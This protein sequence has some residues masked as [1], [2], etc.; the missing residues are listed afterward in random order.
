MWRALLCGEDGTVEPLEDL[1]QVHPAVKSGKGY[2]WLDMHEPD[3]DEI[4]LLREA[5][6]LDPLA[7][8]DCVSEVHHPKIDDYESYIYLAVH[9]VRGDAPRGKIRTR[10]LDVVLSEK[11]LITHRIDPSRSIDSTWKKCREEDGFMVRGTATVLQAVLSM[12]ARHFVDEV[13]ELQKELVDLEEQLFN[14]RKQSYGERVFDIKADIARLRGILVSQRDTLRRI[15]KGEFQVV[16]KR[17]LKYFSDVYD[18]IHRATEI[19]DTLRDISMA[20]LEAHLNIVS[21][22][23]NEIMKV[24][25]LMATF[26]L[27]LTLITGWF[28]MNFKEMT[29]ITWPH[30]ELVVI[31][32]FLVIVISLA[33]LL[34]RKGWL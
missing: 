14:D 12:Q 15:S 10:E 32:L 3:I 2:L 8:E 29:A 1:T 7:I 25:T 19:L 18:E 30:G 16:E 33:V 17:L 27:P 23:T 5:F 13:E 11:F 4:A 20:L 9:G 21:H 34:R 22:R 26:M 24:L 6:E 31:G 28:G